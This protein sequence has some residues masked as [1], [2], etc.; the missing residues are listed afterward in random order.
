MLYE[1]D[2]CFYFYQ[3]VEHDA[4]MVYYSLSGIFWGVVSRAL[5]KGFNRAY[6]SLQCSFYSLM[7]W[8]NNLE[9][10]EEE[11]QPRQ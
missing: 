7:T 4:N 6:V 2:Y 3:V 10:E 8:E 5:C 9:E 11:T 1:T